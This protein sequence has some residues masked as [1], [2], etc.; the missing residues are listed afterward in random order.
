MQ[1]PERTSSVDAAILRENVSGGAV[2]VYILAKSNLFS[3]YLMT[4]L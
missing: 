3:E 4:A 2:D 1:G